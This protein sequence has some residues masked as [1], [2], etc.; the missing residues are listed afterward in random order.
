MPIEKGERF[1]KEDLFIDHPYETVMF[2]WD[3][4]KKRIYRKFYGKEE[5]TVPIP[6]DN[7]LFNDALLYGTEI[8]RETYEKGKI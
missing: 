3:H 6:H 1:S 4:T 8:S 7:G 2:R 5:G